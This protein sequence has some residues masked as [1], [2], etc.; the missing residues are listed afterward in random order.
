MR[1]N[2][3]CRSLTDYLPT[4]VA[5]LGDGASILGIAVSP[6]TV[7][8]SSARVLG[9]SEQFFVGSITAVL[10]DWRPDFKH[11][12]TLCRL[13]L[14]CLSWQCFTTKNTEKLSTVTARSAEQTI[15]QHECFG[16]HNW[17]FSVQTAKTKT[18]VLNIYPHTPRAPQPGLSLQMIIWC[19]IAWLTFSFPSI[20]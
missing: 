9:Y 11:V 15:S 14:C 7:S 13:Q 20:L 4:P 19:V 8:L 10:A 6:R 17:I 18:R 3:H 16:E 2:V 12:I 1:N 5:H